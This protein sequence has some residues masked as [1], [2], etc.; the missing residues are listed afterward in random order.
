[1]IRKYRQWFNSEWAKA[2]NFDADGRWQIRWPTALFL[3]GI[4]AIAPFAAVVL[5]TW[6]LGESIGLTQCLPVAIVVGWFAMERLQPDPSR[7]PRLKHPSQK[8][9]AEPS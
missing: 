8:S 7:D 5:I 2:A 3:I 6:A 9:I 4:D 1:M